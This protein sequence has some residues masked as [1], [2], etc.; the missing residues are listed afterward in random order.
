MSDSQRLLDLIEKS[1]V[2]H[3]GDL[4]G[5]SRRIDDA[6][7]LFDGRVTLCAELKDAG[8]SAA[9]GL[10]HA[11]ILMKLHDYDDE[12]LD[13]CLFGIGNDRDAALGQVALIW[14]T[15]VAG[16]IKSFIDNKP[17][18][19]TCQAGVKGGNASEGYS[20]SDYGLPDLRAFVGPSISRGFDD[21]RVQSAIDDTKPWFRFA[22]ESAAPRRVHLAKATIISKGKDGWRWE[23]E[24]DGHDVSLHDPDW[25]ASVRGPDFGYLTRYTVFEFPRNSLVIPLR[26]KLERTIRYFAENFAK[27]DSV[28]Q[29][30]EAMTRQGFDPDLVHETESIATIAFGRTFFEQ[31][32]VQYSS[33]VI[34]ARRDGRV[35]ADVPLMSISAYSRARALAVQLRET[36]PKDDFQ[37]LC[38]YN[39]ESNA[40]LKAIEA[41]GENLDLTK[42]KM[43]PCV[44]PDRGVSDQTMEAALAT[45][46]ALVERNRSTKKN[47][48]WK[49]W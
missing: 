46:N 39:A 26:A 14:M 40:I 4:G 45:L 49:F 6:L 3:A 24:I 30:M 34:R 35:Q 12:I 36:M 11:H 22:A 1:V 48:W 17:V 21:E 28:D 33:T 15:G 43:Y 27:Y 8:P 18:C 23:L 19:M 31:L 38:L 7:Q 16:P 5:W 20:E 41:N 10:V 2:E 37:S 29:L 47:P 13:A 9:D 44:V 32:G 42:I 25:P